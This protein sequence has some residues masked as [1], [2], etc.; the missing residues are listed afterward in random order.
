MFVSPLHLPPLPAT[1]YVL[2]LDA[3][4]R[5]ANWDASKVRDKLRRD[6]DAHASS[7]RS[8]KLSEMM[9]NYEVLLLINLTIHDC[10]YWGSLNHV[11]I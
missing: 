11:S 1:F 3:S 7:V 5:Q 2:L 8:A 9:A 10:L 6:V 4:I